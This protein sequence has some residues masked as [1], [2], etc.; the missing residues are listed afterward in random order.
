MDQHKLI[1]LILGAFACSSDKA[2]TIHNSSPAATITGPVNGTTF[3]TDDTITFRGVVEDREDDPEQLMIRWATDTDGILTEDVEADSDGTIT[4]STV[5]LSPGEHA[6]SL[7]VLDSGGKSGQDSISIFVIDSNDPPTL[8]IRSPASDG[9][10]V[11]IGGVPFAFEA[12]VGDPQDR[13]TD[14]IVTVS[15]VDDAGAEVERLCVALPEDDGAAVC[16][17]TLNPGV[18]SI[19]FSVED[20]DGNTTTEITTLDVISEN[21]T[22]DDGDGYSEVDGD[23]DDGDEDIHPGAYEL[24][25]GVDDDCDGLV[26]EGTD[27]YDDDEDGFS[28]DAGDCDDDDPAVFPYAEEICDGLDNDCNGTVDGTDATDATTWYRD[29]DSD[30]YGDW[31]F[32][33]RACDLPAGYVADNT[34]CDDTDAE[35]YP[36][37]TEVCDGGD[38]DCDGYTDEDDAVGCTTYFRDYDDDGY[39][40]TISVCACAAYGDYTSTLDTDCYD[41]SASVNPTHTSF[42]PTHRGDGSYDYNCDDAE[43]RQWT[44]T[45]DECAFF[46]DFGCSSSNGWDG[47]VPTCGTTGTWRSDCHY[48]W[49]WFSSGCYWGSS[50]ARTQACR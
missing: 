31:A 29:L 18:Y 37:S 21:E 43:E 41:D 47:G 32:S 10:D 19:R 4:Y 2:V 33:T 27:A 14:L 25:N 48:E 24:E 36:G 45:S 20:T 22:D 38:N 5:G 6:V 28:E 44:D 34:D 3:E 46:A 15:D 8:S 42:H 26:D 12:I 23:C 30:G 7:S 40:S 50:S 11:A 13:A 35:S 9:S 39:G 17:G 49:D 16:E 1:F